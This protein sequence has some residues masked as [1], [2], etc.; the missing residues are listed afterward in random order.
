MTT[1]KIE[2]EIEYRN[3]D[4]LEA[5]IDALDTACENVTPARGTKILA[6]R[7]V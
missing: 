5:T 3:E 1:V 7:V 4:S 6:V 2:I